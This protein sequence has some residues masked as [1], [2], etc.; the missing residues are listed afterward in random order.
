M[1]EGTLPMYYSV[2]V[3]CK[4]CFCRSLSGWC[5]SPDQICWGQGVKYNIPVQLWLSEHFPHRAPI[6]YVVPTSDMIIKPRHSFVDASGI[7]STPY[8]LQWGRS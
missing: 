7:V 6:V 3:P 5:Q 2:R 4:A 8:I 1:A